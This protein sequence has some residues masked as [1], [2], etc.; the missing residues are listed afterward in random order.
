[1]S[2]KRS[3]LTDAVFKGAKALVDVEK[4][5]DGYAVAPFLTE[6]RNLTKSERLLQQVEREGQNATR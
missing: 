1:M 3:F 5:M 4:K 6:K 2:G